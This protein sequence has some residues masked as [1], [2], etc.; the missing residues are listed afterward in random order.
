[1]INVV[2]L[3]LHI[4]RQQIV[5]WDGGIICNYAEKSIEEVLGRMQIEYTGIPSYCD[6]G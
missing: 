3:R 6:I 4:P 5:Y 2:T 1:M